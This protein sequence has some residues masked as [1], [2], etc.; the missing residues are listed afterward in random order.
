[1]TP[2]HKKQCMLFT[3]IVHVLMAN[4][5]SAVCMTVVIECHFHKTRKNEVHVLRIANNDDTCLKLS[6]A[7][8]IAFLKCVLI[9][10]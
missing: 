7:R 8:L 10:L 2:K 1:M 9:L 4:A 5:R 6:F 3:H